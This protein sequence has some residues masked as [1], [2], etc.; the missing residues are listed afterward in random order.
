[1]PTPLSRAVTATYAFLWVATDFNATSMSSE[2]LPRVVTEC[3]LL[4]GGVLLILGVA[5][6]FTHYLIDAQIPDQAVEW[7]RAQSSRVGSFF[8]R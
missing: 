7:P 5:L 4:V 6:G 2:T 1:V 3:G 8:W